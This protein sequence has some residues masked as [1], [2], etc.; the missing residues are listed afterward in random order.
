MIPYLLPVFIW[1]NGLVYSCIKSVRW[2]YLPIIGTHS[3]PSVWFGVSHNVWFWQPIWASLCKMYFS[4]R[5]VCMN[6]ISI[7]LYHNVIIEGQ[8]LSPWKESFQRHYQWM[9]LKNI[10]L[11]LPSLYSTPGQNILE[12][13]TI[14]FQKIDIFE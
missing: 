10:V 9:C 12:D 11:S 3:D 5:P 2:W 1:K 13:N 4:L 14:Q 6:S 7:I 8:I